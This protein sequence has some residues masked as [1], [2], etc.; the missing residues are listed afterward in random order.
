MDDKHEP[1]IQTKLKPQHKVSLVD[2]TNRV[3]VIYT[4]SRLLSGKSFNNQWRSDLLYD[5]IALVSYQEVVA[6][7]KT[8]IFG[9]YQELA[10]DLIKS[11]T[12]VVVSN[13]LKGRTQFMTELVVMI[14]VICIYHLLFKDKLRTLLAPTVIDTE[15]VEDVTESLLLSFNSDINSEWLMN[16][17]YTLISTI[18]YHYV[19]KALT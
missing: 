19:V 14:V 12:L 5:I 17:I 11:I 16:N 3:I 8:S 4:L 2:D 1:I 6:R 10:D 13:M 18:G 7:F 9:R 15:C